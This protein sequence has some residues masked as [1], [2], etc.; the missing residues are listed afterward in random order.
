M[1]ANRGFL[2]RNQVPVKVPFHGRLGSTRQ[3]LQFVQGHALHPS[4]TATIIVFVVHFANDHERIAPDNVQA[5]WNVGIVMRWTVASG[6]G[7]IVLSHGHN[8]SFQSIE[9]YQIAKLVKRRQGLR[10]ELRE[11]ASWSAAEMC[12]RV[13]SVAQTHCFHCS[14][15]YITRMKMISSAEQRDCFQSETVHCKKTPLKRAIESR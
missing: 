5:Q 3:R 7:I 8:P 11:T 1:R 10:E 2:L 15:Q 9:Q 4:T 12:A 13:F 6:D 14:M